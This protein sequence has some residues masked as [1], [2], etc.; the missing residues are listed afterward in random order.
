M[1]G[2]DDIYPI[3]CPIPLSF[4]IWRGHVWCFMGSLPGMSQEIL[5]LQLRLD[6]VEIDR[7]GNRLFRQRTR[8][9]SFQ[10]F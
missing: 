2:C 9:K 10:L 1:D 3:F 6:Y 4:S 7:V 5:S 8:L